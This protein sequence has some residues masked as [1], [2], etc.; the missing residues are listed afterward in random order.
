MAAARPANT[1]ATAMAVCGAEAM[2]VAGLLERPT[3]RKRKVL[4]PKAMYSQKE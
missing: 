3:R 2:S 1:Q 4:T